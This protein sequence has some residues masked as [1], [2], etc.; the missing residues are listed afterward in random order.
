MLALPK[1]MPSF[2]RVNGL[3]N[4]YFAID[5]EEYEYVNGQFFK[6]VAIL[7]VGDSFG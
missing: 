6:K 4:F 2:V 1:R 3:N 7:S 5:G